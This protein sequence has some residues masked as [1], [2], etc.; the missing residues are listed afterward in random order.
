MT[1]YFMHVQSRLYNDVSFYDGESGEIEL[2]LE[3]RLIAANIK[4]G[5]VTK[6]YDQAGYTFEADAIPEGYEDDK[7]YPYVPLNI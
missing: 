7:V 3:K 4:K 1:L 5:S 6:V 2:G